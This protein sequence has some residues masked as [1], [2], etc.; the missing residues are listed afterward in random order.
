[1]V[2]VGS[3]GV[4]SDPLMLSVAAPVVVGMPVVGPLVVGAPVVGP[5]P[6]TQ[7]SLAWSQTRPSA[8]V[9]SA[10]QVQPSAP[11]AQLVSLLPSVAIEGGSPG[12][13]GRATSSAD[14]NRAE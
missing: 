3:T 14:K 11:A 1:V 6:A 5:P 8:Q 2:V 9:W 7:V 13:P 4:V 10:R 12:Q